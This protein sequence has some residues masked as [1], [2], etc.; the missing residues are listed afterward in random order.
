MKRLVSLICTLL[1]ANVLLAQTTFVVGD[2][3]YEITNGNEVAVAD[4]NESATSVVIP[5]TITNEGQT[6]DV[7]SIGYGAFAWC[8]SLTTIT[9]PNSITSIGA[10]GFYFCISLNSITIPNSV[11]SIGAETFFNCTGLTSIVIPNSVSTIEESTFSDCFNL[12]FISISRGVTEIGDYAFNNCVNLQLVS[13]P[14]SVT[15]IGMDAFHNCRSLTS[16]TI[17]STVT[18]IGTNAFRGCSG[19][20]SVICRATVP[21]TLNDYYDADGD[22][23]PSITNYVFPHPNNATLT[24][25]CETSNAYAS[26]DWNF[27]F[28]NRI[29]E[30]CSVQAGIEDVTFEELSF[31]PNPSKGKITFNQTIERIDVIDIIGKTLQT[32]ENANEINIES[33]PSGVYH[34]RITTGDKT[35]MRKVIKEYIQT[36]LL[37]HY[38]LYIRKRKTMSAIDRFISLT[39]RT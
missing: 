12:T 24:V 10:Q 9:I 4:C 19:L 20:T 15:S 14:K 13:I 25:P 7:T 1:C 21:P 3:T 23:S 32:Y 31:Y 2:L 36:F 17:P 37:I 22:V 38:I 39:K 29:E 33:L 11:T 35:I 8:N 5:A 18:S 30:D 16:I 28:E 26:S 34:L 27:Y 6:Y